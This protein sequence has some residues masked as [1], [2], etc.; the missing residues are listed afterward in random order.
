[1][2]W[3]AP[4]TTSNVAARSQMASSRWSWAG[5]ALSSLPARIATGASTCASA[6]RQ[7]GRVAMASAASAWPSSRLRSRSA[8]AMSIQRSRP[9]GSS[10]RGPMPDSTR[11]LTRPGWPSAR[12]S[13]VAPPRP[14]P[15]IT[16]PPPSPATR[17]ATSDAKSS[18]LQGPAGHGESPWPRSSGMSSRWSLSSG[19]RAFWRSLA[20]RPT[21]WSATTRGPSPLVVKLRLIA[22]GSDGIGRAGYVA[23]PC[24]V[25]KNHHMQVIP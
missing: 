11:P 10:P 4:S 24:R 14:M 23:G 9:S 13:A 20:G 21:S 1:M 5:T 15:T 3:P 7:S 16:A 8:R 17:R 25:K 2:S 6:P 12:A 22:G 18:M 19:L